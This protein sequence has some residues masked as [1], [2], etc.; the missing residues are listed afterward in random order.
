MITR[1]NTTCVAC[2]GSFS[3]DSIGFLN[4]IKIL[5][6]MTTYYGIRNEIR[7]KFRS[8]NYSIENIIKI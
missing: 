6:K 1:G 8:I 4:E 7:N 5:E 3:Y 2:I